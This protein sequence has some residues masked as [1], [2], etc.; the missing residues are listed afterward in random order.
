MGCLCPPLQ[1]QTHALSYPT[2]ACSSSCLRSFPTW[3]TISAQQ[4]VRI[5]LLLLL[6]LQLSFLLLPPC[7]VSGLCPPMR[8]LPHLPKLLLVGFPLKQ[9][10]NPLVPL[11]FQLH[12]HLC[13]Q[14]NPIAAMGQLKSSKVSQQDTPQISHLPLCQSSTASP[15]KTLPSPPPP[16]LLRCP[17]LQLPLLWSNRLSISSQETLLL[18]LC[19]PRT[20]WKDLSPVLLSLLQQ[21][22]PN[23]SGSQEVLWHS[24]QSSPHLLTA[25]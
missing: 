25:P 5:I 14:H 21:S 8:P 1:S 22:R 10:P 16:L 15:P 6:H 13:L 17:L 9:L 18:L 3:C 20:L 11:L 19:L 24:H 2:V 12:S 23:P 4:W 7:K